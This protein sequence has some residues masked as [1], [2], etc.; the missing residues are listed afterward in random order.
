[1]TRPAR[2]LPDG[3]SRPP[4][5]S[6]DSGDGSTG[7]GHG[8]IYLAA[9]LLVLAAA[10]AYIN[11]FDGAFVYDDLRSIRDNRYIRTLWPLS[12]AMSLPLINGGETVARRP[13]LS[14]SFALNHA[15]NSALPN[16][17]APWGYHLVNLAI[18]LAAALLLMGIIRR[19]LRLKPFSGVLRR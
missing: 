19:T 4:A 14:L 10:A 8:G 3:E 1:M 6:P 13:V 11:S 12:E 17:P 2:N 7:A 18:H 15:L 5:D 9:G 16:K